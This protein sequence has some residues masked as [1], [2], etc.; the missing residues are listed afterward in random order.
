MLDNIQKFVLETKE[1]VLQLWDSEN[2]QTH[3]SLNIE[4]R[5][6]QNSKRKLVLII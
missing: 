4:G 3:Q 2:D 6:R 5:S 1:N